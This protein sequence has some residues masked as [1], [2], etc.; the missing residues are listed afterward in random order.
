MNVL[1]HHQ[2]E[3]DLNTI[4]LRDVHDDVHMVDQED[5]T[6]E[7]THADHQIIKHD[8]EVEDAHKEEDKLYL[9]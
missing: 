3:G 6:E 1:I 2:D 8:E 4:D 9:K 7:T 5:D